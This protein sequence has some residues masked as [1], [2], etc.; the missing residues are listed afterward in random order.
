MS[1][2]NGQ[3]MSFNGSGW[4]K[5]YLMLVEMWT[6]WWC[7][8]LSGLEIHLRLTQLQAFMVIDR[9]SLVLRL[10]K[11]SKSSSAKDS[12][13]CEEISEDKENCSDNKKEVVFCFVCLGGERW[14]WKSNNAIFVFTHLSIWAAAEKGFPTGREARQWDAGQRWAGAKVQVR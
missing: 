11:G 13:D 14:K 6:W 4:D 7:V 12:E 3:K 8:M 5:M 1:R 9:P 2:N 10:L